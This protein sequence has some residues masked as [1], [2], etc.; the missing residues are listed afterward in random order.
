MPREC[1]DFKR[2]RRVIAA[3]HWDVK[4]ADGI[5]R[6]QLDRLRLEH[7]DAVERAACQQHTSKSDVVRRG[8][9]EPCAASVKLRF[10]HGLDADRD[11]FAVGAS[12]V[13]SDETPCHVVAQTAAA[14][15][16]TT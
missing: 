1:L 16:E 11:R 2:Q 9:E 3:H 12:H 10:L 8:G 7:F 15:S 5:A 14:I 13:R 4:V 6:H